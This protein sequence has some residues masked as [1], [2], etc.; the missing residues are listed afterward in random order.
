MIRERLSGNG[1][2]WEWFPAMGYL[3]S[4]V[5]ICGQIINYFER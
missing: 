2:C 3:C 4:S 1:E 5:F